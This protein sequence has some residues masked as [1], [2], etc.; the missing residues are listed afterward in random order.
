MQFENY[1][2]ENP[3]S[4][5]RLKEISAEGYGN[6]VKAVSDIETNAL[7]IGHEMNYQGEEFLLD[8]GSLQKNL[9]S[10]NIFPESSRAEWLVFDSMINIRPN[11]GKRSRSIEDKNIQARIREIVEKSIQQ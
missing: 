1:L 3:I 4:L 10:F 2:I 7:V 6:M 11:D 8:R 5:S 9:W